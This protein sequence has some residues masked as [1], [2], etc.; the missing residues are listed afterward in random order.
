MTKK[1]VA[2]SLKKL[3]RRQGKLLVLLGLFCL[4]APPLAR[5]H[6]GR[7]T[8]ILVATK[9]VTGDDFGQSVI[10]VAGNSLAGWRGVILNKPL[11]Q[12]QQ[13]RLPDYIRAQNLQIDYG[14]P[15][16][17]PESLTV[18]GPDPDGKRPY[19]FYAARDNAPL[20]PEILDAIR[21]GQK[22]SPPAYRVFAGFVGWGPLQLEGE[23]LMRHYWYNVVMEPDILWQRDPT[24]DWPNLESRER[25]KE[26]LKKSR[27]V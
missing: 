26:K 7:L 19:R 27:K 1:D 25:T 8:K 23:T 20:P 15:L 18:I 5:Y 10:L 4:A 22:Q 12:E 6:Y 3:R 2:P 21:N 16:G 9:S 13:S 14:G 17:F 11:T 24:H